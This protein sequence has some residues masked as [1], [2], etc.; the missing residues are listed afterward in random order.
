VASLF[1]RFVETHCIR[2]KA[3]DM[4][5]LAA[6]SRFECVAAKVRGGRVWWANCR[7]REMCVH[8]SGRLAS[9]R[10]G[11][12]AKQ[13]GAARRDVDR[14]GFPLS[15]VPFGCLTDTAHIWGSFSK[16]GPDWS[17]RLL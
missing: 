10:D 14:T 11:G 4:G 15:R 13:S 2:E 7:T 6:V 9:M 5:E 3:C 16:H 17:K 1:G 8:S 12:F